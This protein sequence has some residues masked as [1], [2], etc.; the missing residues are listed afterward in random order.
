[1][2]STWGERMIVNAAQPVCQTGTLHAGSCLSEEVEPPILVCPEG[3]VLAESACIK[4][5]LPD[6]E[7]P[8]DYELDGD[9][10]AR[11]VVMPPDLVCQSGG[12]LSI[13]GQC[14]SEEIVAASVECLPGYVLSDNSCN[15]DT[16]TRVL[17]HLS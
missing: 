8:D 7:C 6:K 13:D 3:F 17:L 11:S 1:M 14:I 12:E 16:H 15:P 2:Q 4:E 5:H 9:S 10:C